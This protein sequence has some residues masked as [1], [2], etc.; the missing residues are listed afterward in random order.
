MKMD[1]GRLTLSRLLAVAVATVA[2]ALVAAPPAGASGNPSLEALILSSPAPGWVNVTPHQALPAS[3]A[4]TLNYA[5][6]D[7]TSP[8]TGTLVITI[9]NDSLYPF[10]KAGDLAHV[11]CGPSAAVLSATAVPALADSIQV[12]CTSSSGAEVTSIVWRQGSYLPEVRVTPTAS[13]GVAGIQ[14]LARRQDAAI[15]TAQPS[16]GGSTSGL[17]GPLVWV[18][19]GLIVVLVIVLIALLRRDRRRA[20]PYPVV[21]GPPPG[22]RL[23]DGPPATPR[24]GPVMPTAEAVAP[25]IDSAPVAANG[26]LP[27]FPQR[28]APPAAVPLTQ[29]VGAAVGAYEGSAGPTALAPVVAMDDDLPPF[30]VVRRSGTNDSPAPGPSSVDDP[31]ANGHADPAP[32]AAPSPPG[33]HRDPH[34]GTLMQYWDGRTWTLRRRWDGRAWV[35]V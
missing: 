26:E 20:P 32:S 7:F 9:L 2:T 11:A 24:V 29:P 3:V 12:T 13:L 35:D 1:C 19:L 18:G 30:S 15:A 6:E 33:W 28:P 17:H 31:A 27:P 4:E 16:S 5:T 8:P 25:L 21:D 34:D 10:P 23:G 14:S 22:G